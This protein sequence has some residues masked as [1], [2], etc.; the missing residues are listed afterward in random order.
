MLFMQTYSRT[1][2]Y[3]HTRVDVYGCTSNFHTNS[4]NR[5][6]IFR[7]ILFSL[8]IESVSLLDGFLTTFHIIETINILTGF[9]VFLTEF[10]VLARW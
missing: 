4:F 1:G 8:V 3:I 6:S 7:I 9:P 10:G 5:G 2:G